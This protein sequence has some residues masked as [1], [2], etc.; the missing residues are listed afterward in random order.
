MATERV[1]AL[2]PP[3]RP[4]RRLSKARGKGP[5]TLSSQRIWLGTLHSSTGGTAAAPRC[6]RELK[7]RRLAVPTARDHRLPGPSR[8]RASTRGGYSSDSMLPSHFV[9]GRKIC[10][11]HLSSTEAIIRSMALNGAVLRWFCPTRT[12]PAWGAGLFAPVAAQGKGEVI[13]S[14]SRSRFCTMPAGEPTQIFVVP[15]RAVRQQ[16]AQRD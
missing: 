15:A 6:H 2:R 11:A 4:L 14:I 13:Q 1:L 3:A 8:G 12:K 10:V 16:A 9:T 7:R 5:H